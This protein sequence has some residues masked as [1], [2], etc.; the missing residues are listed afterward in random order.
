MIPNRAWVHSRGVGR[1]VTRNEA[2]WEKLYLGGLNIWE[3]TEYGWKK[4]FDKA[5]EG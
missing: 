3:C 4:F 5:V 2:S 1:G